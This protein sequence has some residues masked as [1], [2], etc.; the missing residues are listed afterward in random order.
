MKSP[1]AHTPAQRPHR[2]APRSQARSVAAAVYQRALGD[3]IGMLAGGVAFFGFL[4]LFPALVTGVMVYGL[5]APPSQVPGQVQMLGGV[6]PAGAQAV[7]LGQLDATARLG[8]SAQSLSV[9]VTGLI[10]LW[11]A[12]SGTQ[13]LLTAINL[14]HTYTESRPTWRLRLFA[15]ALTLAT[16]V[17]A[18]AALAVITA[19]PI[20]ANAWGEP[21]RSIATLL[22]WVL[23]AALVWAC[24]L[25]AYRVAPQHRPPRPRHCAAGAGTAS[26]VWVA[27]T[28]GL[29][30]YVDRLSDYTTLYGGLAGIAVLMLWVYI[31]AYSS[32][33]GAEINAELAHRPTA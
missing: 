13:S 30:V 21:L 6:L 28:I 25:L 7:V 19:L 4:A 22:A 17:V 2:C 15:I 32:L 29:D 9:V 3:H 11:T 23:L 18:L 8:A 14:I 12:S 1:Q 27:G 31:G 10:G 16:V 26:L 24:L 33:L 20:L 5:V